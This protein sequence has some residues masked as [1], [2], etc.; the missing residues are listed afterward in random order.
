MK[1]ME[2]KVSLR[3]QLYEALQGQMFE[4]V[5]YEI[6]RDPHMTFMEACQAVRQAADWYNV[7]NRSTSRKRAAQD[8]LMHSGT[9]QTVASPAPLVVDFQNTSSQ[10]QHSSNSHQF[11]EVQYIVGI[12]LLLIILRA[13]VLF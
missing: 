13:I 5:S 11:K 8:D 6:H 4:Q 9:I 10:P 7:R 3:N 1:L 12:V 2:K